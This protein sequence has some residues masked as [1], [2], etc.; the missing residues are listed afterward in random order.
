MAPGILTLGRDNTAPAAPAANKVSLYSLLG[1][2]LQLMDASGV[3]TPVGMY[4]IA[5]T[6][7]IATGNI[8]F[9]AIPQTYSHL[10]ILGRIRSTIA[11]STDSGFILVNGVGSA[12]YYGEWAEFYTTTLAAG[13]VVGQTSC[14]FGNVSGATGAGPRSQFRCDFPNYALADYPVWQ[15][16]VS[17]AGTLLAG[18]QYKFTFGGWLNV[19]G[20]ITS[21]AII[22]ASGFN[23]GSTLSLYGLY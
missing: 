14:F 7:L 9:S 12:N 4:K 2:D 5:S 15:G 10:I 6:T 1:S 18:G 19:S 13:A 21:I 23:I 22:C 16:E 8:T 11:A 3:N 17:A 20:A